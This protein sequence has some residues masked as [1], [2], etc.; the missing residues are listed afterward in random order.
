[1]PDGVPAAQGESPWGLQLGCKGWRGQHCQ[2][3]SEKWQKGFH[4]KLILKPY[5]GRRVNGMLLGGEGRRNFLSY[6]LI[7]HHG[8]PLPGGTMNSQSRPQ[9][10]GP[11]IR[12]D[13]NSTLFSLLSSM[14]FENM[15]A[16]KDTQSK[17]KKSELGKWARI[18]NSPMRVRKGNE[19]RIF[20]LSKGVNILYVLKSP[21]MNKVLHLLILAYVVLDLGYRGEAPGNDQFLGYTPKQLNQHL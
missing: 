5:L 7:S 9:W 10:G 14:V 1:M 18:R 16:K 11:K 13:H 6:A 12:S 19:V 15:W 2:I 17:E 20:T 4:K 3:W 8:L 21:W